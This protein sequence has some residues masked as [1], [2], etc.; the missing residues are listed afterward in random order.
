[1]AILTVPRDEELAELV[2]AYD[3]G[4][5]SAARGIEAGTVNTSYALTLGGAR[6]FLRLYE[7]QALAGAEAEAELLRHLAAAG[8]PTPAPILGRDGRA[9]RSV[10]GKPAALFPWI[11]GDM[12]CLR[13]VTPDAG[14]AVGAALARM[15]RAGPAPGGRL[16]GGRFGAADLAAR[17]TRI[18]ASTDLAAR[19][20]AGSLRDAILAAD[21]A[22]T[23]ALPSGLVHGDL[24]RDN[25]LWSDSHD[26]GPATSP[27]IAALLDFESAHEGPFAYD[28]AVTIL[29][30][31]FRDT[32]DHAVGRSIVAGYG[33][34]RT[35]E[36]VERAALHAEAIFAA[37]RFTI[38]RITDD[39][40]RVGKRW[41][42]FVARREALEELGAAGWREA[43]AL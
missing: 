39:A 19:P 35:L 21:R 12:L 1:M 40:I 34:V 27:R 11:D 14:R 24:F 37:L 5:L 9:V 33:E 16:G 26:T 10:A 8:V 18:A 13:A 15:H 23:P 41:Q 43:L 42:R 2:S 7:E 25:V 36:E 31:S 29:S 3:L 6:F 20:L 30:W 38:T 22:R 28:L 32:F 17:C 4:R